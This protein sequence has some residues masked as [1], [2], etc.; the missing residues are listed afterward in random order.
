[1]ENET[2]ELQRTI[3]LIPA[4]ATVA[5]TV[6]G[7]GVFFKA[8]A[9]TEATGS[10]SMALF[11]W[12]IAGILTI[13]A[14][15]TSAELAAM[16]PET[17]GLT[18]YIGRTYGSFWG[19]IAGWAQ[20]F[21]HFPATVS[22]IAIAFSTQVVNL[23]AID[24]KWLVPIAAVT[25][26]FALALNL[27]SAKTAGAINTL[28]LIAKL[29]PL[30]LLVVFGFFQDS[31][32]NFS[33]LPIAPGTGH[34]WF[35]ALSSGLLATMFAY[36]GWIHIGNLAGEMKNPSKDLPKAIAIGIGIIMIVYML[37]NAVFLYTVPLNQV[38]GN[39]NV[40]TDVANILFGLMGSKLITIGI[41]I[42]VYGGL[43]GHIMT[44]MRIPYTLAE[45]Q[46][47]P[48]ADKLS[49]LNRAGVP[50]LA[51]VLQAIVA[52]IIV[53]SGQFDAITNMIVFV[54]WFFYCMTFAGVMILRKKLPTAERPYRVPFYPV[55][56]IV[57]LLGGSFIVI[58]TLFS[59]FTTTM[60]GIGVV[61]L[62]V[63]VYLYLDKKYHFDDMRAY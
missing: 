34:S 58:S 2:K 47:L 1:M 19:Y 16:F 27:L 35:S 5:G 10:I 30:A 57:A 26:L 8:A 33:L 4:I 46:M 62:G 13:C 24:A 14:G 48:F 18:V 29:V 60:V 37:V 7:T 51:G 50:W 55:L 36:D 59:Q 41:M 22:A 61:A 49:T 56:P 63:P 54:I 52:I 38:I 40:A 21:I 17:G 6:I 3:G 28:T 39:L 20:A 31:S 15:L 44:G 23:F 53:I 32:V 43:N 9:I 12:F 45:R 25:I 42:S 11:S